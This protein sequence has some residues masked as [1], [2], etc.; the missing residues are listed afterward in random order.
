MYHCNITTPGRHGTSHKYLN[1]M[2][3]ACLLRQWPLDPRQRSND[4]TISVSVGN[5]HLGRLLYTVINILTLWRPLLPC[6]VPDRVKPSFVICDIRALWCS[7]LSVKSARMSKN[8]K[9]LLHPVWHRML[10]SCTHMTTVGVKTVNDN[11]IMTFTCCIGVVTS[12]YTVPWTRTK[13]G[14]EPSRWPAQL[15]GTVYQRQ[16]V[17][18]T[19]CI[20][21]GASSKHICLLYVSMTVICVYKLWPHVMHSQSGA[22]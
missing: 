12:C 19:T 10:Y 22:D 1:D 8:Y 20:H 4:C 21:L 9:W 5:R 18:L 16:F 14:D 15:Y 11:T 6:L 2:R 17:K 3:K 7:A 13:F